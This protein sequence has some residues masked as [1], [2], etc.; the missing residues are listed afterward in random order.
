MCYVPV[1]HISK[2]LP[3][4]VALNKR[5]VGPCRRINNSFINTDYTASNGVMINDELGRI[6]KEVVMAKLRY[7]P[8]ICLEEVGTATKHLC[9]SRNLN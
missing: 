2:I 4:Q 1:D 3:L 7:S 9:P 8:N 6:W 5:Y